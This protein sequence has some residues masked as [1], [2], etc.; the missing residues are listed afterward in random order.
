MQIRASTPA[1]VVLLLVVTAPLSTSQRA[2]LELKIIFS[3]PVLRLRL[4]SEW[5]F[6]SFPHMLNKLPGP[7]LVIATLSSRHAL[8]INRSNSF[9]QWS[10]HLL[11]DLSAIHLDNGSDTPKGSRYKRLIS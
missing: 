5:P 1:H 7:I 11:S 8:H 6:E 9:R 10:G 4:A 2:G 3:V